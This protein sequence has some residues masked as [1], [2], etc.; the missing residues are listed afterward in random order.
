MRFRILAGAALVLGIVALATLT[1]R[2]ARGMDLCCLESHDCCTS[3][4]DCCNHNA[5]QTSSNL[6]ADK[7][8]AI[9]NFKETVRVNG[10]YIVGPVLIVHDMNKMAN[11]EPCTSFYRFDPAEGPKA[12]LVSFHCIPKAA[13]KRLAETTFKTVVI[14]TGVKQLVEYQIAGD[15]EAHGIPR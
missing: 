14:E 3:D 10:R 12:E 2:G 11:G 6:T 13:Q 9:V 7:Q 15:D 1:A 5:S 4:H 8:W